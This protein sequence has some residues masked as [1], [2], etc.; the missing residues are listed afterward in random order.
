MVL[1]LRERIENHRE[2]SCDEDDSDRLSDLTQ[3][4]KINKQVILKLESK[5]E[6][7]DTRLKRTEM[8]VTAKDELLE[9]KREIIDIV[10]T[11]LKIFEQDGNIQDSDNVTSNSKSSATD[12][13]NNDNGDRAKK[14][15]HKG[16]EECCEFIEIHGTNG[17]ILNGTLQ[18]MSI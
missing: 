13:N 16:I 5:L 17:A 18:W 1:K 6:E 3:Q 7:K 2:G 12:N 10:K 9:A 11:K 14:A 8:A 4:V 15:L